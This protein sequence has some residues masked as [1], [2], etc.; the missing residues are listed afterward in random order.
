[1]RERQTSESDRATE[2]LRSMIAGDGDFEP[3]GP[4][5]L[6]TV[7]T[8]LEQREAE[9][10]M[11]VGEYATALRGMA[12]ELRQLREEDNQERLAGLRLSMGTVE[13]VPDQI[14]YHG[15]PV[16]F[17][18]SEKWLREVLASMNDRERRDCVKRAWIRGL[19]IRR[20][21][22]VFE[23]TTKPEARDDDMGHEGNP[24]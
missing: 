11:S 5:W 21:A 6:W 10:P 13:C 19:R 17:Q 4:G 20:G 24:A 16:K 1:M 8:W 9:A 18:I 15:P 7:A 23:F 3:T 12:D 2:T 22:L 14:L